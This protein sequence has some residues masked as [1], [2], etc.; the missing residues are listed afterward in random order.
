M[1]DSGSLDGL[2]DAKQV[3]PFLLARV[4]AS[5]GPGADKLLLVALSAAALGSGAAIVRA[6]ADALAS[7]LTNVSKE[8]H[9]GLS[10]VAVAIGAV[11]AARNQGI[12]ET[13]VS[14]NIVY[15]A[16][17]GM[18]FAALLCGVVIRGHHAGAIMATGFL[19]SV[20]AYAAGWAGLLGANADTFSMV[21]GSGLLPGSRLFRFAIGRTR[22]RTVDGTAHG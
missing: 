14:L 13:M 16:S 12:V 9:P 4:A 21:W 1:N 5:L 15:I 19:V 11:I 18:T 7:V 10:A 2:S 20:G 6:M 8:V 3:I 22:P 17:I